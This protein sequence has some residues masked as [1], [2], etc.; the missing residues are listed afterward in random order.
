MHK[1]WDEQIYQI[2]ITITILILSIICL[3]PLVYIVFASLVTEREF[4]EKGGI[5][6]WPSHPTL[7]AYRRLFETNLFINAL[8]V[9]V[10]KTVIGTLL[11]LVMTTIVAYIASRR[12]MPGRRIVVIC[13]LITIL[14]SGGLIPTF[15]VVK[16]MFLLNTLWALIIPGMIDG[17]NVL[18]LKQF[19]ENIPKEVEESAKMDGADEMRLMVKIMIPMSAP[20]M[21]AIGLFI[22]V[23]NWNSWFDA[24][25]Y[26][27]DASKQPLQLIM[28]NMLS[29]NQLGN[30]F[31][32]MTINPTNRLSV[33]TIKMAV[34][35][36][37][38]LPILCVY[39]FLQKYFTKGMF[40]GAVKG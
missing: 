39:P 38:T 31:N 8:K 33:I 17:F 16:E 2:C 13:I 14:F 5:I 32:P 30:E 37:G 20:A 7:L 29:S 21:A 24:L 23:N 28:R 22:A 25:I 27:S 3:Y 15:L 10:I 9:S 11:S 18:V 6:L 1:S 36:L 12:G 35:V 19:F 40:L 4:L 34:V 26:I